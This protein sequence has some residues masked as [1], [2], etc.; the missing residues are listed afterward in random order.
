VQISFIGVA[1]GF[2]LLPIMHR[3][4]WENAAVRILVWAPSLMIGAGLFLGASG[5]LGLQPVFFGFGFH[6]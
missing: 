3:V 6:F 1:I 5:A 2:M 4:G